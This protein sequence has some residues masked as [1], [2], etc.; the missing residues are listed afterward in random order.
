[1]IGGDRVG[2]MAKYCWDGED[3][4]SGHSLVG[5]GQSNDNGETWGSLDDISTTGVP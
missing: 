3:A 2:R 4:G 1:M 5:V